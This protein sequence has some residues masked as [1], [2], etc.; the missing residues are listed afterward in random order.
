MPAGASEG[1]EGLPKKE[2]R[3]Q[4][5]GEGILRQAGRRSALSASGVVK[6]MQMRKP[7][8]TKIQLPPSMRKLLAAPAQGRRARRRRARQRGW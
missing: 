5:E 6:G 1:R 3:A 8:I 4:A 7:G 2:H